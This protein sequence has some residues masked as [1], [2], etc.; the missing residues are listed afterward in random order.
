MIR[1]RGTRQVTTM[2]ELRGHE[3]S[4]NIS[5]RDSFYDKYEHNVKT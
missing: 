3:G 2:A 1:F 4:I 5:Q